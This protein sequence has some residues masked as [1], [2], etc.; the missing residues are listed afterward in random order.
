MDSETIFTGG[1]LCGAVR[2]EAKGDPL[3]GFCYCEDCRKASGSGFVP[4]I[5]FRQSEVH[6]TGETLKF[7]ANTA[8]GGGALRHSCPVCGSLVFGGGDGNGYNIYAGTLDDASLFQPRIA[9]FTS[10]APAWVA[11]PPGLKTFPEAPG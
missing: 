6:V 8:S 3:A 9:I 11:I 4:F 5:G 7:T 10:R 1:C 2:Y